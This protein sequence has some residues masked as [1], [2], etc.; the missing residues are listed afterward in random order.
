MDATLALGLLAI[1]GV[2]FVMVLALALSGYAL[3]LSK[4]HVS[5]LLE[6]RR[7]ALEEAQTSEEFAKKQRAAIDAEDLR[8][9][10]LD[11]VEAANELLRSAVAVLPKKDEKS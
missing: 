8:L 10:E 11:A 5:E 6:T 9:R 7:D 2:A 3:Y 4:N 1:G